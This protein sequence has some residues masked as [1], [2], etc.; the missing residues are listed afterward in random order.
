VIDSSP[1][2]LRVLVADDEAHIRKLVSRIVASLG[3]VVVAEAGDGRE[4]VR[5]FDRHQPQMV[6]L[7][8]NMPL[9]T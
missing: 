7:D 8:I 6:I 2:P 1:P 4:A 3:G 5:E 9:M